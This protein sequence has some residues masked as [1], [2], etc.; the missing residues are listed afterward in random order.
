MQ[1]AATISERISKQNVV[2]YNELVAIKYATWDNSRGAKFF[3]SLKK[4]S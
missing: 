4:L 1:V 3:Y 2:R